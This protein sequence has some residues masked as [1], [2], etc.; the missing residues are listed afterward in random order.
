MP[1]PDTLERSERI[2]ILDEM[3]SGLPGIA[4]EEARRPARA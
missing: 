3:M 2:Q 4:H 1:P